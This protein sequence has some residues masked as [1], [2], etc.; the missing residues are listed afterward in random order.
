MITSVYTK[1]KHITLFRWT[2]L[3]QYRVK[4]RGE[5]TVGTFIR[6]RNKT[7]EMLVNFLDTM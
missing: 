1:R 4:K 3:T 7:G 5:S 6:K 2:T